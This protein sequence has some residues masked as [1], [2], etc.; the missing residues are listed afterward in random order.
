MHGWLHAVLWS[1]Q[2]LCLRSAPA[3]QVACGQG[4]KR[5]QVLGCP[6]ERR[7]CCSGGARAGSS[8]AGP[9][10]D[11]QRLGRSYASMMK[12]CRAGAGTSEA[13]PG[14]QAARQL[15]QHLPPQRAPLELQPVLP[16]RQALVQGGSQIGGRPRQRA[17][18][19]C[20]AGQVCVAPRVRERAS[21]TI[22]HTCSLSSVES[23]DPQAFGGLSIE[24]ESSM[25]TTEA[26]QAKSM[27]APEASVCVPGHPAYRGL[28]HAVHAWY[29]VPASMPEALCAG[30]S[31]IQSP[32]GSRRLPQHSRWG[33]LC[34]S[35]GILS[36][37]SCSPSRWSCSHISAVPSFHHAPILA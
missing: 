14:S 9:G 28:I 22:L 7:A 16:D 8:E 26:V 33:D 15:P 13:G 21:L 12:G 10:R 20:G 23:G 24:G 34:L 3:A 5:L 35:A 18:H 2:T 30:L 6:S 37:D 19:R 36:P 17:V 32:V 29:G 25:L 27:S 4:G 11:L 31:S 1:D